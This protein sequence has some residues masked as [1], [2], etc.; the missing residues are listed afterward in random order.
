MELWSNNLQ[1]L[2]GQ[3]RCREAWIG[4]REILHWKLYAK[5]AWKSRPLRV[6]RLLILNDL[7]RY[8]F[9]HVNHCGKEA[10]IY[11]FPAHREVLST[12]RGDF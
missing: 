11:R 2:L 10:R 1:V 6:Y 3:R 5:S 12:K 7:Y 8:L 4:E 9:D